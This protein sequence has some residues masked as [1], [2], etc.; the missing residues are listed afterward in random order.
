MKPLSVTISPSNAASAPPGSSL[1]LRLQRGQGAV[2][3]TF[4]GATGTTRLK[5]L[6]QKDPCRVLFPDPLPGEP[7]TAVV[8]TTS[9]GITGGDRL[10]IQLT[11]V[12]G[13]IVTATSQAA[14]KI[15][16]SL[17]DDGTVH[18]RVEAEPG[19][20]VEWMP[21]ETILFNGG[22]LCRRTTVE[23]PPGST[24]MAA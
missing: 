3:M 9:G 17:G 19:A 7:V 8:A 2:A 21:Q 18:I 15:Y 1:G 13:A 24:L 12:K 20:W 22:R 6:Y 10:S 16:R 4:S 14:E 11:A 23:A 5:H